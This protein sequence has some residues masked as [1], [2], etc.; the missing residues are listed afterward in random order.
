MGTEHT[1]SVRATSA[2]CHWD[3]SPAPSDT[4]FRLFSL[5]KS[6]VS[7]EN[8][9]MSALPLG[10]FF[11]Y[12]LTSYKMSRHWKGPHSQLWGSFNWQIPQEKKWHGH[13]N[14]DLSLRICVWI[15]RRFYTWG[16]SKVGEAV[17]ALLLPLTPS[18]PNYTLNSYIS[19]GP[20]NL[21]FPVWNHPGLTRYWEPSFQNKIHVLIRKVTRDQN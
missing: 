4:Y 14:R 21:W 6:S 1:L 18:R 11:L 10:N 13:R 15:S 7:G 2:L 8:A 12:Y 9:R 16:V 17:W 5:P 3:T 19:Q 20:V